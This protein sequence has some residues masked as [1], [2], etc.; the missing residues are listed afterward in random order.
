M[1]KKIKENIIGFTIID[2][3]SSLAVFLILIVFSVPYI[4][5]YQTNLK[6]K[7]AVQ[8][9]AVN[10]RLAQQLTLSEQIVHA[11]ELDDVNNLYKVIKIDTSTST[12]KIIELENN[13]SFQNIN[14]FS[15]NIVRFNFYGGVNET[16]DITIVNLEG[17]TN[18]I[19]VRPSGYIQID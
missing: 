18:T 8:N 10:L 7:S 13:L 9:I 6:M 11:V 14:G 5:G 16:G 2:I 3:L 12:I 15:N 17:N 19:Y 4:K 1:K